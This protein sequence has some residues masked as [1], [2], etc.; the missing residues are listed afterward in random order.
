MSCRF[1]ERWL[2]QGTPEKE[3]ERAMRHVPLCGACY[4][5]F[6]AASS[7]EAA[8]RAEASELRARPAVSAAPASPDFV[9]SVMTR[10][11]AAQSLAWNVKLGRRHGRM[12]IELVTDPIS[13]VLFTAALVVGIWG[14][15]RPQWF[16]EAG[17]KLV[18][19]WSSVVSLAQSGHI[20]LAPAVWAGVAIAASPVVI[21]AGWALYRRLER[22]LLLLG[23]RPTH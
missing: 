9:E 15:L 6:A 23:A 3:R 13:M 19:G 16:L 14:L 8:L 7:V 17:M 12:W 22:T 20:D 10:V 18:G 4:E 2:D 21:W 1:V 11:A 5:A